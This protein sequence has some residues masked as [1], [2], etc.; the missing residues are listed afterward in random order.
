MADGCGL[1]AK[2]IKTKIAHNGGGL[3]MP[4]IET[5]KHKM[6]TPMAGSDQTY[7]GGFLRT[8]GFVLR[9]RL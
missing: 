6:I 3:A 1:F 2:R 7:V 8:V 9:G 4:D 5:I